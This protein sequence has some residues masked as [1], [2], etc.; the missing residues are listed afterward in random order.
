MVSKPNM[1]VSM[2]FFIVVVTN[3]FL[4]ADMVV[5]TLM[6]KEPRSPP[7]IPNTIGPW[8]SVNR[9]SACCN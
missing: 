9:T 8:M 4:R 3:F 1:P 2:V 7:M 5:F 6:K